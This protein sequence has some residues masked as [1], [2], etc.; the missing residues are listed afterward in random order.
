MNDKA[1]TTHVDTPEA[2]EIIAMTAHGLISADIQQTL[3]VATGNLADMR[4][5]FNMAHGGNAHLQSFESHFT[6]WLDRMVDKYLPKIKEVAANGGIDRVQRISKLVNPS[7]TT[8]MESMGSK[9]SRHNM[10]R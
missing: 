7:E 3:I 1:L 10:L 9:V 2:K 8:D 5:S 6:S 4:E